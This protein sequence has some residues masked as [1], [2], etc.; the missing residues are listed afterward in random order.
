MLPKLI[1]IRA[2]IFSGHPEITAVMG[3]CIYMFLFLK[4]N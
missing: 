3:V 2:N 1:F 4:I